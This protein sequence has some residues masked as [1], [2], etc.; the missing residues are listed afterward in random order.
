MQSN[1]GSVVTTI[2]S[3]V[4]DSTENMLAIDIG[5]TAISE[6]PGAD[7]TIFGAAV[8]LAIPIAIKDC[9][10]SRYHWKT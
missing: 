4:T 9:G 6:I 8:N 5:I 3:A 1:C 2:A 7:A 10:Y